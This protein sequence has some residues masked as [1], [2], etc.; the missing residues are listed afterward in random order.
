MLPN[1][2]FGKELEIAIKD[3]SRNHYKFP[4][5][6]YGWYYT[7]YLVLTK[8]ED[9]K[10]VYSDNLDHPLFLNIN[11]HT[12]FTFSVATPQQQP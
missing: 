10:L 7:L 2:I 4:S 5:V 6:P 8:T 1:G 3:K 11:V 12:Q 9:L